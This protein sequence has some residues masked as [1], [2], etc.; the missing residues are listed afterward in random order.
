MQ[1]RIMGG[2]EVE[3][4]GGP[5]SVRTDAATVEETRPEDG[6]RPPGS[7]AATHAVG[8]SGAL[9]GWFALPLAALGA[10]VVGAFMLWALG[11][12]PFTAYRALVKGAFGSA[13]GLVNTAIK[14]VPLLLVG[15]GICIAFPWPPR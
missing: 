5:R 4:D 11:A 3:P 12:N 15:A 2:H 14:A 8:W 7:R 9:F 13:D 6:R 1:T 10:L